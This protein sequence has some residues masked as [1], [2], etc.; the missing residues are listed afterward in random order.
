MTEPNE[1]RVDGSIP[2]EHLSIPN[3]SIGTPGPDHRAVV[4]PTAPNKAFWRTALQVGPA[5][6]LALLGIL[7]PLLQSIVDGFGRELPPELYTYLVSI[8][9]GVTLVASIAAKIM[10]NQPVIDWFKKYAPFFAPQ[11]NS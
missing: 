4:V 1:I 11:K 3:I 7:P 9:A 10:A 8:T 5:A 2:V 6:A